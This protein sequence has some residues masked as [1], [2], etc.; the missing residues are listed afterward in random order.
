M[1]SKLRTIWERVRWGFS[2]ADLQHCADTIHIKWGVVIM[3]LECSHHNRRQVLRLLDS[4]RKHL[5][6]WNSPLKYEDDVKLVAN[7]DLNNTVWFA[8]DQSTPVKFYLVPRLREVGRL[9]P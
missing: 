3:T 4:Q 2:L 1:K 8:Y 7:R 5:Q 9:L 6:V